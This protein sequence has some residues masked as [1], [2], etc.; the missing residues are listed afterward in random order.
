MIIRNITMIITT[1]IMTIPTLNMRL[2]QLT[3][4]LNIMMI[5]NTIILN[6]TMIHNTMIRNTIILNITIIHNTMI[7]NMTDNIMIH[8]KINLYPSHLPRN[9]NR[10]PKVFLVDFFI[11]N[12]NLNL[13]LNKN[14]ISRLM[15][16][17]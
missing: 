7:H 2:N 10:N 4:I 8:I 11:S 17:L 6:I 12:L 9:S 1:Q 15:L 3:M 13:N 14:Q 5:H 16:V